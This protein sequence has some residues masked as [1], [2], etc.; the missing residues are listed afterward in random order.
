M[1]SY[2]G[3]PSATD[4]A[5]IISQNCPQLPIDSMKIIGKIIGFVV[6]VFWAEQTVASAEVPYNPEP[7]Y[8]S[9]YRSLSTA[10]SA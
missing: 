2:G 10:H 6:L 9:A 3:A 4:I 7:W 5:E 8:T 1:A